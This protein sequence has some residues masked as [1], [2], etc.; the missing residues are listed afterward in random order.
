MKKLAYLIPFI[1]ILLMAGI[2]WFQSTCEVVN[3]SSF[4]LRTVV[5]SISSPRY[6][7]R[8]VRKISELKPGETAHLRFFPPAEAEVD[9]AFS[10]GDRQ[11]K[12][13]VLGYYEGGAIKITVGPDLKV[14]GTV[15]ILKN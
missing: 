10:A 8:V 9:L 3:M 7:S 1:V 12:V 6:G 13:G 5:L 14:V 11:I 15:G 4:T 2:V